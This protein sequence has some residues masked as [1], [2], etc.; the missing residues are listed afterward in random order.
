MGGGGAGHRSVGSGGRATAAAS[1]AA[2]VM[3]SVDYA[4]SEPPRWT[5]NSL[6]LMSPY[7]SWPQVGK[8]LGLREGRGLGMGRGSRA[9]ESGFEAGV[10][11]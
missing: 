4:A 6:R 3:A 7:P 1:A 10:S 11:G 8:G 2:A 9:P 5:S